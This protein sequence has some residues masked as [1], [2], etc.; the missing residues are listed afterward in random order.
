MID[1]LNYRTKLLQDLQESISDLDNFNTIKKIVLQT[2]LQ[3]IKDFNFNFNTV[4]NTEIHNFITKV[5]CD[6][7]ND[8]K[9]NYNKFREKV[10][11]DI[12]TIPIYVIQ[13]INKDPILYNNLFTQKS[14]I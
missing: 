2:P 4:N 8:T 5:K 7:I 6:I 13:N 3:K 9:F 10:F 11:N 12:D 1:L 14:F